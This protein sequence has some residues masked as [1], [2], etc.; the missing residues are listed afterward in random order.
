MSEAAPRSARYGA[1]LL[2]HR[3]VARLRPREA[4]W[5]RAGHGRLWVTLSALPGCENMPA[6]DHILLPG[7]RVLVRP[8]QTAVVSASGPKGG[9][10]SFDWDRLNPPQPRGNWR[11]TAMTML[12][13]MGLVG[14]LAR[15]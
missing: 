6:T 12:A 10:A 15:A 7:D 2:E 9:T 11:R 4:R 14:G 13:E 3:K 8:G 1:W 5:L